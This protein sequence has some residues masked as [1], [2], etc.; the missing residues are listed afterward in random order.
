MT[1]LNSFIGDYKE[2]TIEINE[3]LEEGNE[4]KKTIFQIEA[5]FERVRENALQIKETV[6]DLCNVQIWKCGN[7]MS[8]IN[9]YF[10]IGNITY[11][12][13]ETFALVSEMMNLFIGRSTCSGYITEK[14][15][16]TWRFLNH[17]ELIDY[18]NEE[19]VSSVFNK[20]IYALENSVRQ[21][22]RENKDKELTQELERIITNTQY[23]IE[24][25]EELKSQVNDK[26]F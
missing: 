4:R 15:V 25:L 3:S 20:R 26:L 17:Y 21:I 7:E 23:E 6:N 1:N 22:M 10:D 11:S 9:S 16:K 13:R 12:Y 18:A 19:I 5:I 14:F 2:K 24:K 8:S